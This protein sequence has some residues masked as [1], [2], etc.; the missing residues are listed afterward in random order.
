MVRRTAQLT[1]NRARHILDAMAGQRPVL[2]EKKQ[3]VPVARPRGKPA[4]LEAGYERVMK[5]FPRIMKRLADQ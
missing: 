1:G 2:K 4:E 5:R 3:A